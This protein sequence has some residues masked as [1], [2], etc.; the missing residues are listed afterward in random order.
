MER[1][2]CVTEAYAKAVDSKKN[3]L[4]LMSGLFSCYVRSAPLFPG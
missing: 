1:M 4:D 3:D 2:D